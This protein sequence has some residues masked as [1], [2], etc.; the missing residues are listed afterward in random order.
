MTIR[1]KLLVVLPLLLLF[2]NV[3]A[4]FLY[5]TGQMTQSSYESMMDRILLYNRTVKQAERYVQSV[6]DY[7]V[8]PSETRERAVQD[9]TAET[10]A[11]RKTWE[12]EP[13]GLSEGGDRIGFMHLLDTLSEQAASAI[14]AGRELRTEK[15]LQEYEQAERTLSF[16]REDGS[17]LIDRELTGYVPIFAR[18]SQEVAKLH[19]FGVYVLLLNTLLSVATA[20]WISRSVTT[21][22]TRLVRMATDFSEGKRTPPEAL[23]ERSNDELGLL[24]DTFHR[25]QDDVTASMERE[26]AGLEKDRMLKELELQALQSQIHPHFLFNTLNVISKLA[27]LEGAGKTSDLI[28]SLSGLMRYNLRRLDRPSTLRE[29]LRHVEQYIA[30]QQARFRDKIRFETDIAESVLDVPLP[31]LTIQPIV[32]NA[33]VHGIEDRMEGAVVRLIVRP[34]GDE[35]RITVTDNGVGMK[36]ETVQALL[37]LEPVPAEQE[38]SGIGVRNVVKRLQLFAGRG[39]LVDIESR[40]GQGT[41]ITLRLPVGK[42]ETD[43]PL[44]DRG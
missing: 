5:R 15:A 35:V 21:P 43:D 16:I 7:L 2:T 20:F 34:A 19:T 30:I 17:Q 24:I 31:A 26:K 40:I 14:V 44:I 32:E 37:R 41:A 13:A 6:Y 10:A 23:P 9:M 36:P 28:V 4:L 12:S 8:N 1:T 25:M 27:L 42:G 33:F 3:T 18:L 38:S 39:D 11:A 29:E 22:V